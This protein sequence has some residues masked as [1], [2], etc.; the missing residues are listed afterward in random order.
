M[1]NKNEINYTPEVYTHKGGTQSIDDVFDLITKSNFCTCKISLEKGYASGFFCKIISPKEEDKLIRVLFTCYHVL[2]ENYFNS[3]NEIYLEFNKTEKKTI[4]LEN[5]LIWMNKDLDYTCIEIF[6]NDNITQ[7]LNIDEEILEKDFNELIKE[8]IILLAYNKD[9]NETKPKQGIEYGIISSYNKKSRKFVANYNSS[10]GASGGAILLKKNHKIIGIHDGGVNDTIKNEDGDIIKDI[11][12]NVFTSLYI[13]LNDMKSNNKSF[14]KYKIKNKS[15]NEKKNNEIGHNK[16]INKEENKKVNT[17]KNK[18]NKE[19]N[20]IEDKEDNII[21][22]KEDNI[23]E[24]KE[25]IIIENK[26][27]NKYINKIENKEENEIDNKEENIFIHKIENKEENKKENKAENTEEKKEENKMENKKENKEENKI[28][29]NTNIKIKNDKNPNEKEKKFGYDNLDDFLNNLSFIL[30]CK[31]CGIDYKEHEYP[32][33][34]LKIINKFA[35]SGML[36]ACKNCKKSNY[37]TKLPYDLNVRCK[38]CGTKLF[39]KNIPLEQVQ[40][41]LNITGDK[42]V[43]LTNCKKCGEKDYFISTEKQEK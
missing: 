17:T 15:I 9:K 31:E 12:I 25:D 42:L 43:N 16:Y 19:D 24:N 40:L 36:E 1:G 22:N 7:F 18:K 6:K 13:I 32:F 3:N 23:I 38:I 28:I 10:P 41:L 39:D 34:M 21:E 37:G 33:S 2:N 14:F 30:F 11:K 27:E 35:A 20:I 29:D 8:E 5:R 4:Y 26:E